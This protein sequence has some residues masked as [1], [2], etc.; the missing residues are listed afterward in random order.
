MAAEGTVEAVAVV[1]E[2]GATIITMAGEAMIGMSSE[3]MGRR[4]MYTLPTSL[5]MSNGSISLRIPDSNSFSYAGSIETEK[6]QETIITIMETNQGR[7]HRVPGR[8][9]RHTPTMALFRGR[10]TNYLHNLLEVPQCPRQGKLKSP[11][12][13]GIEATRMIS[14]Q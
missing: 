11:R 9:P 4:S 7:Q 12:R 5:K 2:V 13:L 10:C 14:V 1:A 8:Y 3:S 6:G